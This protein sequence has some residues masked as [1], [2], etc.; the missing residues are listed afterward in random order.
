MNERKSTATK[1][2]RLIKCA[3]AFGEPT[4]LYYN[5]DHKY[6]TIMGAIITFIFLVIMIS[7]CADHISRTFD[8]RIQNTE[9]QQTFLKD[10][11]EL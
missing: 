5:G 4:H 11:G 2:G 10:P 1:L 8:Y 7:V 6:R 9:I 3:D